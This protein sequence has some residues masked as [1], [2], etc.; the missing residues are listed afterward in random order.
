MTVCREPS[1]R[2]HDG[3]AHLRIG[4]M[5]TYVRLSNRAYSYCATINGKDI[6]AC[7]IPVLAKRIGVDYEEAKAAWTAGAIETPKGRATL[8]AA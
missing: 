2:D 6:I 3:P 7:S 5:Q 1:A 8:W 4:Y